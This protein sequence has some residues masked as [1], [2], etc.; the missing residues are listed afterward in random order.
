VSK[1]KAGGTTKNN[2][3]SAG[4]RLGLKVFAGEPVT[5]GMIIVRQV[6]RTKIPGPGTSMGKDYTIFAKKDG[7]VAFRKTRIRRFTGRTVPRTE[8]QVI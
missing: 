2:R 8:V 6:G 3:D 1:T 5:T 7:K 4:R